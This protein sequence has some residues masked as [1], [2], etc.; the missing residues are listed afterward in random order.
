MKKAV[1]LLSSLSLSFMLL[2]LVACNDKQSTDTEEIVKIVKT[3]VVG[4]DAKKRVRTYPG[5]VK[6]NKAVDL[7]F[8]VSGNVVEF[9]INRGQELAK[10]DFVAKLDASDYVNQLNVAKAELHRNKVQFDR[11]KELII[12]G[13]ISQAKYD[14]IEAEF[15]SSQAKAEIDQKAVDDTQLFAP[16]AGRVAEKFIDNFE[17]IQAKQHI[18]SLQAVDHVDIVVNLPEQDILLAKQDKRSKEKDTVTFAALGDKAFEVELKEYSTEADETT[19]TFEVTFTMQAPTD[20][21]ILPGMT[22]TFTLN[23]LVRASDEIFTIPSQSV[24]TD[25]QGQSYVWLVTQD[26]LAQKKLVEI[27]ELTQGNIQVLNGLE[28]GD[29]VVTA[30]VSLLHEGLK[31]KLYKK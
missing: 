14:E 6:A 17:N 27:G 4:D 16:F 19:Q 11:A 24:S 8:Q 3:I 22:A 10:G 31:V 29:R 21:S 9:P 1:Q 26:M 20:V 15:L 2:S 5:V 13:T 7:T 12:S 23:S 28:L 18:I 30:G 25:S